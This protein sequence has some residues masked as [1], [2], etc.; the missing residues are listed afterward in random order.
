MRDRCH[1]GNC[2]DTLLRHLISL[3][4]LRTQTIDLR[5][6]ARQS[7]RHRRRNSIEL[8]DVHRIRA[9][10]TWR[11]VDDL[12]LL[13]IAAYRDDIR[14]TA[15]RRVCTQRD[16]V[17]TRRHRRACR[18]GAAHVGCKTC[19]AYGMNRFGHK[20]GRQLRQP[21]GDICHSRRQTRL[22]AAG[23]AQA[24]R[25]R[26]QPSC[27]RR[28]QLAHRTNGGAQPGRQLCHAACRRV[29]ARR[30]SC[31]TRCRGRRQR[32]DCLDRR[33]QLTAVDRIRAGGRNLTRCNI[34]DLAFR[35]RRTHAHH[36]HRRPARKTVRHATDH[37]VRRRVR[38]TRH[39]ACTER[40]RVRHVRRGVRTERQ[41]VGSARRRLTAQCD[42]V[43]RARQVCTADCQR[44][45][46]GCRVARADRHGVCARGQRLLTDRDRA[47]RF[48]VCAVADR[49]TARAGCAGV[50]TCRN[51]VHTCCAV[52]LVVPRLRTAVVHT[53]VVRLRPVN[54]CRQCG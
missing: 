54:C 9:F 1:R 33:I 12:T 36:T 8:V 29:Q 34:G 32:V 27:R 10:R 22:S 24:R 18:T 17:R 48:R 47:V 13:R 52:V 2:R 5:L 16:R 20:R 7:R 53:V 4:Q 28:R 43:I 51:R 38:R 46:A 3:L 39:C 49:D 11:N 19:A 6:L 40:H 42:R 45:G 50:H 30:Q 41:R 26:R 44:A 21:V 15:V 14:A 31:E 25:Q 23:R 37:R 35:T